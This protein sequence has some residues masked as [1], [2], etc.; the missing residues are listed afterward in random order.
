MSREAK[1]ISSFQYD[2]RL[3]ILI[4]YLYNKTISNGGF[5]QRGARMKGISGGPAFWISGMENLSDWDK[6]RVRLAGVV[7]HTVEQYEYMAAARIQMLVDAIHGESEVQS[8]FE[9][10]SS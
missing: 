10:F 9:I 2:D 7:I 5:P 4:R 3:N 6:C 1:V 8:E